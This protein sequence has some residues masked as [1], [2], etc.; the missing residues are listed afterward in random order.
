MSS[1]S[2]AFASEIL[3]IFEEDFPF[4]YMDSEV[5]NGLKSSTTN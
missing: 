1:I 4:Y 3:D 2:E 5:I